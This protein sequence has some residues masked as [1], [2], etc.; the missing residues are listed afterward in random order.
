MVF[1]LTGLVKPNETMARVM[2]GRA[3]R[4]LMDIHDESQVNKP[5]VRLSDISG[6]A[7]GAAF[8][9]SQPTK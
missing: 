3:P 8:D 6:P 9:N 4:L 2:D 1:P 5:G 7:T